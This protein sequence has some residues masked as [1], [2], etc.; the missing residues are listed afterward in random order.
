[1]C[2]ITGILS[3]QGARVDPSLLLKMTNSIRHRGPDDEG[4]LL[5]DTSNNRSDHRSGNDSIPDAKSKYPNISAPIQETYNLGF[6]YRRLS[7]IDLSPAGHQPMSNAEGTVWLIFNGEIYN[8]IELRE[9][10]IGERIFIQDEDR[11]RS[12]Y[13][14]VRRMGNRLPFTF[15]RHVG[16]CL[17][18]CPLEVAVLR[19]RPVRR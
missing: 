18:G 8:Y 9:Q 7:I 4:Y 19:K 12:H 14:I 17:V 15:Q 2:G 3:R 16:V 1:M 11:L 10:L 13:P 5:V 6:G